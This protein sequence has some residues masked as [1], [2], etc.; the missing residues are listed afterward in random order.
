MATRS[1]YFKV[2]FVGEKST[3][4]GMSDLSAFV[5]NKGLQKSRESTREI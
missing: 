2:Q 4:C 5:Y 1:S 3:V